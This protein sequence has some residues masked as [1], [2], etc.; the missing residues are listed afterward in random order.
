M[1]SGDTLIIRLIVG[2][3]SSGKQGPL[4]VADRYR[5]D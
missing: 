3:G 2:T 4:L 1:I 5:L